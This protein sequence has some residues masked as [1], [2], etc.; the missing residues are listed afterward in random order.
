MFTR[1]L[2]LPKSPDQSFFL[3]GP[4]QTGKTTLLK[5]TYP[6]AWRVDL[7]KSDDLM[8]Y[9]R[10]PSLIREEAMALEP[11]KL[12][13]IDEIQKAPKLLDEVHY[14]IQEQNR[15]FVLC[16]SSARKVKKGH[17]NLLGG[18]AL[19]YELLGLSYMELEEAF[20]L[21]TMLNNG[22]LPNHYTHRRPQRAIQS[23]V[24]DYLKEE[25]LHEGLTRRL[26]VFSDF[27][28]VAAIGDTGIVNL[29]N[30]ARES[31]MSVSTVRDYYGILEDT[32]MGAFLPAYTQRP[33]RRI[34]KSPKFYFRDLGVVN[35]LSRRGRIEQGSELFGKAFENWM[36]HELSIH[37]RYTEA[38]YDLSYWH[39]TTGVEVDFVIG[40]A[41]VAV[42]V[43]AKENIINHDLKGLREFKKEHPNVK[44]LIVVALVPRA[45]QTDDGIKILPYR[46][47]LEELWA[48]KVLR[49]NSE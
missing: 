2:C 35:C 33:K 44:S 28:R 6:D 16:G 36:F 46:Q 41:D 30:I 10:N 15:V 5:K 9:L 8:R 19:R 45:R 13:V 22:P 11:G 12:V 21:E 27:L 14:M 31:S 32:L 39:L 34:I 49:I 47:F 18:R 17:V 4:R 24:D 38:F 43:K 42:E 7:L 37:S 29:S 20:D 40:Q 48:G 26:P 3:W 23:Y 25:I 1:K